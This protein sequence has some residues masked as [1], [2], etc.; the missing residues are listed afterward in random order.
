MLGRYVVLAW[1]VA[2]FCMTGQISRLLG[3]YSIEAFASESHYGIV[4]KIAE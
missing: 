2:C 1:L 3:S 4:I